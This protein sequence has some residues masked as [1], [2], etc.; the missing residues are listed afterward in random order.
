MKIS[1]LQKVSLVDFDGHISA[2]IFTSG[3][4]FSCP[5]CHN[6]GL[7]KGLEP[8]I[9]SIEI[10]EYLEKR[11]NVL[12]AVVISGGEPT[13]HHD[14]PDLIRKIKNMGYLIKLDTNGTN[15]EMLKYLVENKLI[16]YIA[17]DIKNSLDKYDITTN[18]SFAPKEAIDYIMN[19]GLDYEFRTTIVE[20]FHT[21]EDIRNIGK[22]IAGANK[23]FL[24][25]FEDS[26]NCIKSGLSAIDPI[27]ANKF[28]DILTE[29]IPNTH[30]R[31]YWQKHYIFC[32]KMYYF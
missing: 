7:V 32:K 6:A 30:L 29:Y 17:M 11:S 31:G 8:E 10:L 13:L 19:C 21:A 25:K 14:L 18:N 28:K 27:T 15:L 5:Y 12:D 4:N 2:T 20:G 3:C 1:G 22:L 9:P 16:D 24:Q 23:Y 26:G